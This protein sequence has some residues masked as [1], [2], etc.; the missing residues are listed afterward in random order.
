MPKNSEHYNRVKRLWD[1]AC[2]GYKCR[3][4]W[5]RRHKK[6]YIYLAQV[7]YDPIGESL[8]RQCDKYYRLLEYLHTK[9]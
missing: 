9:S 8:S 1:R 4:R 3:M 2:L 6:G 5:R 7:R